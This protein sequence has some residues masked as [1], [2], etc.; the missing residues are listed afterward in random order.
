MDGKFQ[1]INCNV[2]M[3]CEDEEQIT[4]IKDEP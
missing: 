4:N 2:K 1:H 3:E